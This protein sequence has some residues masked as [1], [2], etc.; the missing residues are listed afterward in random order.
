MNNPK[1]LNVSIAQGL[2]GLVLLRLPNTPPEDMIKAT[3]KVWVT[4]L[5]TVKLYGG[6]NEVEDKWRIESAFTRLY[7]EC[8]RFPSPKMLIERLPKRKV[9]ELPEPQITKEQQEI[10]RQRIAALIRTVRGK[11]TIN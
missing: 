2:A 5:T 1:W 10:N 7:A 8:D 11:T 4:A 6:W 9:L 3:A